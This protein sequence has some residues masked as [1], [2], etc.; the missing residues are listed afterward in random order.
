MRQ[1]ETKAIQKGT[2]DRA[3][4]DPRAAALRALD[5]VLCGGAG[6]QA[7]LDAVLREAKLVPSDAG[8]CT[9]L[10]YG[11]LRA[12]PLLLW[13]HERLL[14]KPEDLPAEMRLILALACYELAF[15]DKVPGYAAVHGAVSRVRNRFGSGLASVA[16]GTLRSFQR[17]L[18]AFR[19]PAFY[20]N[21]LGDPMAAQALV[22]GLPAWIPALWAR[23]YG[24]ETSR[25]F[26]R[27]AASRPVPGVRVNALRP[28]AGA[29]RAQLIRE[30]QGLPVAAW[31]VAFPAGAPAFLRRAEQEGRLSFQS[32]AVQ[33]ALAGIDQSFLTPPLWDACAGRGG[34]SAALLEAGIRVD[35]A[36][37]T[38]F[39]RIRGL[40]NELVRLRATSGGAVRRPALLCADARHAPFREQ[41]TTVIADVPCS[42][43]GTL[44]RRP[45]IRLRRRAEDTAAFRAAQRDILDAAAALVR[46]GGRIIYLTCTLT[47][48]ENE[49]Q[50]ADF[51]ARQ[52][53]FRPHSQWS[54]PPASPWREFL[55]RAIL[56]KE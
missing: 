17:H 44:S 5:R 43:L 47:H 19:D 34:K 54:T 35:A 16:N 24:E 21:E 45:E 14:Q 27:A 41:F 8:L 6:S 56:E 3:G 38:A 26:C 2:R 23:D 42:G 4:H 22:H 48:E 30:H 12:F 31:G 53:L 28:D 11:C 46:P 10:V 40:K 39:T 51:L 1:R 33:E 9:E 18:S 49:G 7:A 15:L 50:I 32:P 52:P 55:F 29:L 36:A 37:D 25:L 13:W 20:R